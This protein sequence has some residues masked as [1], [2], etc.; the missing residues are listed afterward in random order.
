MHYAAC[1]CPTC[2][3][4][5]AVKE[6]RELGEECGIVRLSSGYM[7]HVCYDEEAR[8]ISFK[9]MHSDVNFNPNFQGFG[10]QTVSKICENDPYVYQA[11]GFGTSLTDTGVLCG[12]YFC[13]NRHNNYQYTKCTANDCEA[14]QRNCE[15]TE[16]LDILCD[17]I[18]GSESGQCDDESDC[19]G[20]KYGVS[21]Q[22]RLIHPSEVC[23]G[24][25]TCFDGSDEQDCSVT[26]NTVNTCAQY[27]LK[28]QYDREVRVPILNYT[29]CSI[30]DPSVKAYPYCF[31]YSDQTNCSDTTRIGGYCKV[32]GFWTSVSKSV[33]CLERDQTLTPIRLCDDESQM[34]CVSPSADCKIHKH[35]LCDS[36]PDC[37]FDSDEIKDICTVMT[38]TLNFSCT[39]RFNFQKGSS[40]I[41]ITWLMDGIIDCME[42]EDEDPNKWE[43][44]SG[45]SKQIVPLGAKCQDVFKCSKHLSYVFFQQ[46]C[47][48][49]ESCSNGSEN[50]V[51][52]IARDFPVISKAVPYDGA[53]RNLCELNNN[54]DCEVRQFFTPW[55]TSNAYGVN[56]TTELAVPASKY[57]CKELFGELYL[58]SSCMDLCLEEEVKCPFDYMNTKLK[59]D[60]CP[61]EFPERTYT[62]VNNSFL[63]FFVKSD[64]QSYHQEFYQCKNSRC[65]EYKQVC[66]LI[67]DCGDMSDELNCANHMICEDTLN[68]TKHQ[69]ISLGQKCDGIYDCFDLS[70]ECNGECGK[71]ILENWVL[72]IVCWSMGILAVVLNF[73]SVIKGFMFLHQCETEQMMTSTALMGLIS[74]GDFLIGLYLLILS[75]YDSIILGEDYCK[76]QAEWLTGTPCLI[77]G[78]IS[79]L[80]SQVS[81]FAMTVLSLIR[82][83]GITCKPMRLPKPAGRKDVLKVISLGIMVIAAALAVAVTPLMPSLEDYFVQGM[84]YDPA[85]KVFVGFPNKA[86]HYKVFQ[87]YYNPNL[88]EDSTQTSTTLSWK[89]IVEKVEDMFSQDHGNLTS[90]PVHFYG[91]DGVCLFKYFVRTDD[92]R[93]SRQTLEMGED[94]ADYD[95]GNIVVWTM[96]AVNFFCF[97][98]IT[99]CYVVIVC[100]TRMSAQSSGQQD[101]PERLKGERA[102]Q[103]K[104][105]VII[106]TDFLCWVPFILISGLHNLKYID[107]STW[108]AFFAMT[109]LPLNSVINPLLYDKA[110][111]EFFRRIILRFKELLGLDINNR[112][113][114]ENRQV[115]EITMTE[116]VRVTAI[117]EE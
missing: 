98:I 93:R 108:Y 15:K 76:H 69:F 96:L 12:G 81:L 78:V 60:S 17:G 71:Q 19:N 18:C 91:N 79:T 33:I 30:V 7:K 40:P 44:C 94:T 39:R 51:C 95:K 31:D 107:A 101:S 53:L 77:L 66:D 36:T 2:V 117:T 75:V 62:I 23:N 9:C 11:C 106:A 28:M 32:N 48:G 88:T 1:A 52:R 80:G 83:Y 43:F 54:S 57:S 97:I 100:K 74:S 67:D 105:M 61:G 114:P 87:Q 70:D 16:N 3:D 63:T 72:K 104:I 84:Y 68:S 56:S 41:P 5:K 55:G 13:V 64:S 25:N 34:N 8:T 115:P 58:L 116:R 110:I 109:V 89:E 22:N 86:R 112:T 113:A 46:L 29:R 82:M 38:D 14:G 85:Y 50:P 21:C 102:I 73:F 27:S 35:R 10:Y 65:V 90:S 99:C 92:A 47:D 26:D 20:Y 24:Q 103:N 42:E 45:V 59:H 111:G 4:F 6:L 49:V 37:L